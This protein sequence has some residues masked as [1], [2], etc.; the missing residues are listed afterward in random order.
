MATEVVYPNSDVNTLWSDYSYADLLDEGVNVV[1]AFP[2]DD[3][4]AQQWGL[5]NIT[6]SFTSLTSLKVSLRGPAGATN[7]PVLVSLIINGSE[8][9][10]QSLTIPSAAYVEYTW[11]GSWTKTDFNTSAILKVQ[12]GTL[13]S[14]E[15]LYIDAA[16]VTVSDA[17]AAS[18]VAC[19][20]QII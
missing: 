18:A 8:T 3:N 11:S 13:A 1:S 20:A 9:S 19:A 10:Q 2:S 5:A 17:A 7:S 12:S 14:S 16:K 15:Y 6:G 4:E